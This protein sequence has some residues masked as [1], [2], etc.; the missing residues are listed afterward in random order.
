MK[1]NVKLE[2]LTKGACIVIDFFS[3]SSIMLQGYIGLELTLPTNDKDLCGS[4]S[5]DL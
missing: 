3:V 2:F 5:Q 1:K 4:D